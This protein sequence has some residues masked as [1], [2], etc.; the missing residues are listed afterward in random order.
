MGVS[1]VPAVLPPPQTSLRVSLRRA[2]AAAPPTRVWGVVLISGLQA[3]QVPQGLPRLLFD[4]RSRYISV[5]ADDI[6]M[7]WT[8]YVTMN[9]DMLK[10]VS[11]IRMGTEEGRIKD[12]SSLI[13]I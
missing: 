1:F 7:C 4:I 11:G 9:L 3:Y 6:M 13:G 5:S 10:V 2:G 8:R 12:I